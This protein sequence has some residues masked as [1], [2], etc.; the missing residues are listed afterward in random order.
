MAGL[1]R[2]KADTLAP[3]CD[4]PSGT[5][6]LVGP[7]ASCPDSRQY[8]PSFENRPSNGKGPGPFA[9]VP[10][11]WTV[12]D[13]ALQEYLQ[14][15]DEKAADWRFHIQTNLS[16]LAAS[17]GIFAAGVSTGETFAFVFTPIPLLLGVYNLAQITRLEVRRIAFL[18]EA[19]PP[20]AP[21]YERHIAELRRPSKESPSPLPPSTPTGFDIWR[22]IAV[23]LGLFSAAFPAFAGFDGAAVATP[24][25]LVIVVAAIIPSELEARKRRGDLGAWR[26]YWRS[27]LAKSKQA[28]VER[29]VAREEREP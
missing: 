8:S 22:S 25:T 5:S 24:L 9:A 17:A 28:E 21:N 27:E 10:E 26:D 23:V 4:C 6:A 1:R 2:L 12:A 20:D 18:I 29:D 3:M 14:L 19:A 7:A 11:E 16:M 13:S 15:R